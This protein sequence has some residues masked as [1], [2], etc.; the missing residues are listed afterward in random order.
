MAG[1]RAVQRET[2]R[3]ILRKIFENG[4]WANKEVFLAVFLEKHYSCISDNTAELFAEQ[5]KKTKNWVNRARKTIEEIKKEKENLLCSDDCG[6]SNSKKS[7]EL[8]RIETRI[9]D[10]ESRMR[11][12]LRSLRESQKGLKISDRKRD[13]RRNND[14]RLLSIKCAKWIQGL[15]IKGLILVNKYDVCLTDKGAQY[16]STLQ[17]SFAKG[18]AYSFWSEVATNLQLTIVSGGLR[19]LKKAAKS[20][21]EDLSDDA[22]LRLTGK[23][24]NEILGI[25]AV[26]LAGNTDMKVQKPVVKVLREKNKRKKSRARSGNEIPKAHEIRSCYCRNKLGRLADKLGV[27]SFGGVENYLPLG[28]TALRNLLIARIRQLETQNIQ[29][30]A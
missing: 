4:R 22:V 27:S 19:G 7:K 1:R 16:L 6:L 18:K 21:L 12:N 8:R 20:R 29:E 17:P 10:L 15:E 9:S 13:G 5:V 23:T 30:A 25:T 24:K 3:E 28:I 26:E 11:L 14:L 2:G